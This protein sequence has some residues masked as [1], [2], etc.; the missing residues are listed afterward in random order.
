M[1]VQ[2]RMFIRCAFFLCAKIRIFLLL[3][4]MHILTYSRVIAFSFSASIEMV[5]EL[6]DKNLN[7]EERVDELKVRFS[8][9]YFDSVKLFKHPPPMIP[10][11]CCVNTH[12]HSLCVII[13]INCVV[14]VCAYASVQDI[15]AHIPS[16][17]RYYCVIN[18]VVFACA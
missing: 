11:L 14:F 2:I 12:T 15:Y 10:L 1:R 7:L 17:M 3:Q 5:E 9:F 6:T 16:T 8:A 18:C 4:S 13:V